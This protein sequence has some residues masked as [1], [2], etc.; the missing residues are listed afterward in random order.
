MQV[1]EI[2]K[3][4]VHTVPAGATVEHASRLMRDEEIGFLPVVE[5]AMVR[6]THLRRD[7]VEEIGFQPVVN[8]DILVGVLTDRDLVVRG[9]AAEKDPKTTLVSEIMTQS[10]A[11]CYEDDDISE[12][13]A[14][15][16][17]EK[18][19]RL[20]ALNREQRIVGVLSVDDISAADTCI[21]GEVLH[22]I[23]E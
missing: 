11:C 18:V 19:R 3:R 5:E 16:E 10:F 14:I 23:T 6:E 7:V 9:V 20:F 22:A 21:S 13:A 12:A 17:R 15:M 8:E 1:S 4:L 2:M